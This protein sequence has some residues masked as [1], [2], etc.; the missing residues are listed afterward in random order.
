MSMSNDAGYAF[1]RDHEEFPSWESLADR[2]GKLEITMAAIGREVERITEHLGLA[3][4]EDGAPVMIEPFPQPVLSRHMLAWLSRIRDIA[5]DPLVTDAQAGARIYA[6]LF[7][8]CIP[9]EDGTAEGCP[10]CFPPGD[11][12]PRTT[13]PRCGPGC[14]H[15]PEG[16]EIALAPGSVDGDLPP[17]SLEDYYQPPERARESAHFTVQAGDLLTISWSG[18]LRTVI[19]GGLGPGGM[20]LRDLTACEQ[21]E[22]ERQQ[23]AE[24]EARRREAP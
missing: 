13:S 8:A 3:T 18:E 9:H 12:I 10:G 1:A 24:D 23:D 6:V 2:T 11:A 14:G 22:L 21:T 16:R 5:A 7:P 15:E 4:D 20:L 17:E 19:C